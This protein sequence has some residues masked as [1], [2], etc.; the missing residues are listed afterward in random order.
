MELTAK[1]NDVFFVTLSV[2]YW[3]DV[4]TRPV[5]KDIVIENLEF[6]QKNKGLEIFSFVLMT[7]HLHLIA[8]NQETILSNTLRDFKTFTSKQLY[9]AI[10]ENPQESRKNWIIRLLEHAGKNNKLNK[11]FQFW[12]NDNQP[13]VI[14]KPEHFL[15]KQN[16]I[17]QNPVRTGFVVND[18]EYLYSSANSS[19]ILKIDDW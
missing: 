10:K 13:V 18:F 5:Y 12:Q 7:N 4:F 3:I 19:C 15:V 17:H 8:R 14:S 11:K 6:C 1:S 16:Y 9:K 2:V